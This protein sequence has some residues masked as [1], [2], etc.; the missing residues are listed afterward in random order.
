MLFRPVHVCA[1][2]AAAFLSVVLFPAA[3]RAQA[4]ELS[5]RELASGQIKKGVRSIGFGG[6]GATTGNYA[7]VYRDAG[8]A[9]VDGGLTHYTNGNDFTFTAV[10]ATTPALWHGLTVYAIGL[11]QHAQGI[12][13]S[14]SSPGLGGAARP[15]V[16]GGSN[17]AL[18]VKVAMPIAHGFSAG[19]LLSYELSQFDAATEPGDASP[20]AVHY[21]TRWRPSGG[22]GVTWEPSKRFLFGT[23]VILNH[24]QEVRTDSAGTSEA[25][26]RTYEARLGGAV[27]PWTGGLIDVGGTWLYRR[28]GLAGSTKTALHPN[29]GVE[30]N[31]FA[32]ALAL[33]AGLDETSYGAGFSV[34]RRPLQLDVAYVYN[35]GK[36]R[37]GDLFG[38][39]SH[40]VLATLTFDMTW[41]GS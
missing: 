14:L 35:L 17:Q 19:A 18:F 41:P 1:A 7:L 12:H 38:K 16:G 9:L 33:R 23:R 28:N 27:S 29:L 30:Q 10:G 11:S 15:L 20:A 6:D 31:L 37:V 39:T 26:A 32:R 24:D 25:L 22:F 21:E 36:A 5:L 2:L 8:G 4:P 40:S 13:L 34:R 3:V